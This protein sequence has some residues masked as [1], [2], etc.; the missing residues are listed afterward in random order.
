MTLLGTFRKNKSPTNKYTYIYYTIHFLIISFNI[1]SE[2]N[3]F[4]FQVKDIY[5][6]I[7]KNFKTRIREQLVKMNIQN[8]GGPQHGVVTAEIVFYLE[9]M[10]TLKALS[11]KY[12][13]DRAMDDIWTR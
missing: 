8:N 9:T 12:L 2:L 3:N 4:C 10:R 5:E 7:H 6:I 11:E 1:T 13:S